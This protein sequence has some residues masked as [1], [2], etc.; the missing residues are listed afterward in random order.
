MFDF[1]RKSDLVEIQRS[2]QALADA[3]AKLAAISRSMAMIEFAP[4]GTILDAN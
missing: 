4:D 3:Q 2:H 1:H